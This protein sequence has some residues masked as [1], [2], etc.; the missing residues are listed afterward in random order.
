MTKRLHTAPESSIQMETTVNPEH[1][2]K[3]TIEHFHEGDFYTR[4]IPKAR[5]NELQ[6][7]INDNT[8]FRK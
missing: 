2:P 4:A 1:A 8:H 7:T 3:N 6:N 5:Y